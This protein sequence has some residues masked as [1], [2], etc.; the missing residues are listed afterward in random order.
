MEEPAHY[1]VVDGG[2]ESVRLE[3]A[4]L[5]EQCQKCHQSLNV[6]LILPESQQVCISKLNRNKSRCESRS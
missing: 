1:H 3:E 2:G 5:L 4:F 6:D